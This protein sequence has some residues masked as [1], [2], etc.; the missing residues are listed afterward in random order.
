VSARVRV[1]PAQPLFEIDGTPR[2]LPGANY[3]WHRYG[4]FGESV[5]GAVNRVARHAAEIDRDLAAM[6]GQGARAVRWFLF[7][8]G[9]SGITFNEDTGLPAGLAEGAIDDLAAALAILDRHGLLVLFSLLD[10]LA[11]SGRARPVL[12]A[13]NG[14][15]AFVDAVLAPVFDAFGRH[16]A[17]LGWEVMNEPDWI[18]A[19]LNPMPGLSQPVPWRD[20]ADFVRLVADAIHRRTN[21]LA[22]VGGARAGNLARWTDGTLGLDFVELHLYYSAGS[23]DLD[24]FGLPASGLAVDRPILIGEIPGRN[25]PHPLQPTLE[26]WLSFGLAGGYA[27][28]WPWAY[29]SGPGD[30]HAPYDGARMK[31][32]YDALNA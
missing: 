29:T 9:R 18:V 17:V 7:T 4:E 11:A 13:G 1:V 26:N 3:A 23:G 15:R 25:D 31:A 20:F 30:R 19:E 2:F 28:V 8:D 27:G 5:W 32:F 22:T 24:I 12:N 14:G 6:R 10:Y 16:D 21:A